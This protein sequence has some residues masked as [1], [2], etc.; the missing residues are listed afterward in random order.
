MENRRGLKKKTEFLEGGMRS[1]KTFSYLQVCCLE[2]ATITGYTARLYRRDATVAKKSLKPDLFEILQTQLPE[3]W[4]SKC[5]ND[6]EACY[7]M[8]VNGINGGKIYLAGTNDP[9]ML[10]GQRQVDSFMNECTEQSREA[11]RQIVGRTERYKTYDWNPSL[12]DHWVFEEKLQD[13]KE[14]FYCHS[15]FRDNPFLSSEIVRSIEKWEPTE[16][17]IEKG[18]ASWWHW[19][20]YGKG[21]AAQRPGAVFDNWTITGEWPD[22]MACTYHGYGLDFGFS[23]A[24]TALV[25]CCFFQGRLYVRELIY[26]TGLINLKRHNEPRI[27]SLEQRLIDLGIEPH[28]VIRADSAH[29]D[30]IAELVIAGFNVIP[31]EKSPDGNARGYVLDSINRMQQQRI[32]VHSSSQNII[33][34]LKNYIWARDRNDVQLEKPVKEFDHTLDAIRGWVFD[35]LR[36]KRL[37]KKR[38]RNNVRPDTDPFYGIRGKKNPRH[39][40]FN[41]KIFGINV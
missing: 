41:Q 10:K 27:P 15:T 13:S 37:D 35:E 6:R 33:R 29:A 12:T 2:A 21:I 4:S 14:Y 11:N 17:N 32:M 22:K 34:E 31:F 9:E 1:G 36:P 24:P 23:I 19:Q 38:S 18:T 26:E 39:D 8:P 28:E 7:T 30:L 16:Y 5:W 20:V 3:L 40:R 25:E